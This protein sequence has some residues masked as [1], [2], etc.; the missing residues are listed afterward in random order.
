M[1]EANPETAAVVF[2]KPARKANMRK[3]KADD[4]AAEETTEGGPRCAAAAAAGV[5]IAISSAKAS[6]RTPTDPHTSPRR[7]SV[8]LELMKELQR[9]R[10]RAKGVTLE[11]KGDTVEAVVGGEE[12]E[13]QDLS[14][15]TTF[16]AQTD[17]GEVDPNML[18]Y[19]EEQMQKEDDAPK[20][21]NSA[22]A[23]D[24]E[25]L[26]AT[27]AH[28]KKRHESASLP[29]AELEAEDANRWL[30]GIVEV[31]LAP[32]DK[33]AAIEAT[34]LAKR[35]LMAAK[36]SARAAGPELSME[37]PANY[38]ANFHKHRQ[39]TKQMMKEKRGK[40]GGGPG[41]GGGKGMGGLASDGK[42]MAQFRAHDRNKR[43]N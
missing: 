9:Q 12:E 42:A 21:A 36:A 19:I 3:R 1:S 4:D 13:G 7:R 11:P 17:A 24:D 2:K 38:N 41:G 25:E 16:T 37:I 15:D 26:F 18:K 43:N 30:A 33:M 10:Q 6:A 34:E 20:R 5:S 31:S 35:K 40:G 39:E 8:S 28:L 14:L 27:P 32:E 23:E 22:F 29:A